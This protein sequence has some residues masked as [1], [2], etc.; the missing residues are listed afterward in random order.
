MF[1]NFEIFENQLVKLRPGYL[2]IQNGSRVIIYKFDM[3]D[4]FVIYPNFLMVHVNLI[5]FN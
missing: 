4:R 3:N 2:K 1:A 5:M